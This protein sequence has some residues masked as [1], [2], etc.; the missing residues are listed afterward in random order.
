MPEKIKLP[1]SRLLIRTLE[2]LRN[3]PT[4]MTLESIAKATGLKLTWLSY[5]IGQNN[6]DVSAS[7]DRIEVLYEF[8]SNKKLDIQ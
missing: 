3:R 1:K 6:S 4:G 2:L 7:V 8:L 5:I